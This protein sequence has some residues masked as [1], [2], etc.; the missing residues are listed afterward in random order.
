MLFLKRHGENTQPGPLSPEQKQAGHQTAAS[1]CGY[2]K[3]EYPDMLTAPLGKFGYMFPEAP[4]ADHGPTATAELDS[5]ADAMIDQGA[6]PSDSPMPAFFTYIGQFIDHDITA[7]TDRETAF[8][9]VDVADVTPR[10][11]S[12]VEQ[13]VANLRTGSP[14][15]DSVYGDAVLQGDLANKLRASL[16]YPADTAKLMLGRRFDDGAGPDQPKDKAADLLR[17]NWALFRPNPLLSPA[18]LQGLPPDLHDL[19]FNPDGSIQG[20]R[21][22]IGD[23]RNDENLAVAQVHMAMIRFHN[24]LTEVAPKFSGSTANKAEQ[25]Y[26]WAMQQ[27]RWHHQWLLVNEYLPTICEPTTYSHVRQQ[28][29]PIYRDFLHSQ[30]TKGAFHGKLPLPLEFSVAA[31]RFGHSMVRG[32]YDWNVAGRLSTLNLFELTGNPGLPT[33][34]VATPSALNATRNRLPKSKV[35]DMER[36]LNIGQTAPVR[37]ARGIDTR[38]VGI[39]NDM[40][41]QP[42][43][44]HNV[45]KRLAK[46][47]LR[48][49]H[50]LSLPTAQN[51]I[52]ALGAKGV[53]I[54]PLSADELRLGT[55][56]DKVTD[57]LVQQTPLWFYVLKEAEVRHG[58]KHLGELG[59]RIVAETLLG[60]VVQGADTYWQQP[61]KGAET[62]WHPRDCPQVNGVTADSYANLMR[63]VDML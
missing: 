18:D 27:L 58:G 59:S 20:S 61:G 44:F 25:R 26:N 63:A 47:N 45:L 23:A 54:Q 29:A 48:R 33:G 34:G 60:L 12:D 49:G 43:G 31:F 41:N 8:S 36:L 55:I 14:D 57:W 4:A 16:R 21:A 30:K 42:P 7:G 22:L 50:R 35:A 19:F 39:L 52:A 1:A 56:G 46:R 24:E 51:C 40:P 9:S 17:L 62:R 3:Y 13:M 38:L 5:L 28:N 11:R 2:S 37:N 15:L 32:G 10:D 6:G 53:M